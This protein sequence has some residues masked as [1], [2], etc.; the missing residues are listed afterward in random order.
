[1][2][3]ASLRVSELVAISGADATFGSGGHVR[4]EGKGRKQRAVPVTEE[5]F[6]NRCSSSVLLVG[7]YG[8]PVWGRPVVRSLSAMSKIRRPGLLFALE[9]RRIGANL[10]GGSLDT[11]PKDVAPEGAKI[12]RSCDWRRTGWRLRTS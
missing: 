1:V 10:R 3:Q 9:H 8:P 11:W 7:M 12:C 6:S 4:V 5:N 2:I